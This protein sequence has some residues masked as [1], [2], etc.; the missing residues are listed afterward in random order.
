METIGDVAEHELAVLRRVAVEPTGASRSGTPSSGFSSG[1]CRPLPF[2]SAKTVPLTISF[3]LV[4]RARGTAAVHA[5]WKSPARCRSRSS[6]LRRNIDCVVHVESDEV[7]MV[8]G[9]RPKKTLSEK[10]W[11]PGVSW[12]FSPTLSRLA[13]N[14]VARDQIDVPGWPLASPRAHRSCAGQSGLRRLRPAASRC[15]LA[16]RLGLS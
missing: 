11:C 3:A 14:E 7:R 16:P 15:C 9:G 1:S 4:P 6:A 12:P 8:S 10:P 13:V 5:G 2:Q